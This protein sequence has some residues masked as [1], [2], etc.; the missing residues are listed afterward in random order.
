MRVSIHFE[1]LPIGLLKGVDSADKITLV[2]FQL[3]AA[4]NGH[5]L[6]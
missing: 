3:I 2:K 6:C 5:L 4:G 1:L